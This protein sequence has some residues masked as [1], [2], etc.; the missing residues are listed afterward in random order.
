VTPALLALGGITLLVAAATLLHTLG[1]SYRIARLLASAEE[2]SIADAQSLARGTSARYVRVRGRV[3]SDEE[4]PDENQRP[5]VFRRTR[6][7]RG[8]GRG[9]WRRIDE[10]RV[11][12][13]F[14]VEH[15]AAFIGVDVDALGDGLVVI[16]RESVGT[17]ADLPDERGAGLP[18]DA[19]V[20]LRIDQVSAVEQAIVVGVPTVVDAGVARMAPGLGRPL[21][22]STLDPRDAMR[23]LAAGRRGRV[24]AA[25]VLLLVGTALLA[26]AVIALAAGL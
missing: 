23:L 4:F 7:E 6:L 22:V 21:I 12:V 1:T 18:G 14:G 11:A 2:V 16:P 9:R 19:P 10:D 13:P 26:L 24:T 3:S 15:R 25:A 20:R 8:D 5:L 17:A